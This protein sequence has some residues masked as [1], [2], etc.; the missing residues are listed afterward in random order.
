MKDRAKAG[1]VV[2]RKEER[3]A[4]TWVGSEGQR[5]LEW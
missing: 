1:T 3:I 5:G 2:Q 4:L